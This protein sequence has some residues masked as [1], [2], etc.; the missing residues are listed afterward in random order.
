LWVSHES[1]AANG[2]PGGYSKQHTAPI[3]HGK[4]SRNVV[5]TLIFKRHPELSMKKPQPL[6][7]ARIR[8]FLR[9]NVETFFAM[10]KPELERIKYSAARLKMSMTRVLRQCSTPARK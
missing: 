1:S 3:T 4:G 9:E 8:G 10:L 7:V 2:F 5:F 6:S